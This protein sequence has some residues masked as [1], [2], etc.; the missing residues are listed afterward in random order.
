MMDTFIHGLRK[1]G[2]SFKSLTSGGGNKNAR[3]E[4]NTLQLD[5][6]LKTQFLMLLCQ[7]LR[8]KLNPV[9]KRGFAEQDA[10]G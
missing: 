9:S 4:V 2:T 10:R 3:R 6:K 1:L 7:G 5:P 8:N